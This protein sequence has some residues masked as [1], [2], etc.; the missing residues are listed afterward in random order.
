MFLCISDMCGVFPY[1]VLCDKFCKHYLIFLL[2]QN[3]SRIISS[4]FERIISSVS[5]LQYTIAR[6][7]GE[8]QTTIIVYNLLTRTY[9]NKIYCILQQTHRQ[10]F[11]ITHP[12]LW[13]PLLCHR[14]LFS[15]SKLFRI[16]LFT[17]G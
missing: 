3:T 11:S 9:E 16:F 12:S 4:V 17:I 8:F 10:T 6:S 5:S 13:Y 7:I 1:N 2:D 14:R 15:I